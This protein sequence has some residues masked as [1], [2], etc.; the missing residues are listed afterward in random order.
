MKVF[1]T[2]KAI[3]KN[4]TSLK[5]CYFHCDNRWDEYNNKLFKDL[6]ATSSI[7]FKPSLLYTQ[8]QNSVNEWRIRM[9]VERMQSM[10]HNSGLS[11]SFWAE[12][13]NMVN[14]LVNHSPMKA[15]DNIT[16]YEAWNGSKLS[17]HH[18]QHFRYDA[19]LHVPV[20]KCT[21]LQVKSRY[22]T[23]LG[24]IHNTTKIWRLWD[25]IQKSIINASNITFD[26]DSFLALGKP[27]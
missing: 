25:P 27:A 2:F 12:A 6:L 16:S 3:T 19:Y 24:Y 1:Q 26:E 23:I 22:Y 17:L 7:T 13:C 20:A 11:K 18:L 5:I 9:I 8:N 4:A 10:L 15:L 14:Y 21:E